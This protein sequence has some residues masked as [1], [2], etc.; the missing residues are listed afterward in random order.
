[1][2]ALLLDDNANYSANIMESKYEQV[3]PVTV[4]NQ[5]SHLTTTNA[6]TS[7]PFLPSFTNCFPASSVST[8]IARSTSTLT[9]TQD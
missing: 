4:A 5:Q 9:L 1:M 3:S 6:P 7:Q 8:R 2:Q